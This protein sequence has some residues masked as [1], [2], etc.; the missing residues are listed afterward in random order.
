MADAFDSAL[1]ISIHSS[2]TGSVTDSFVN[3]AG[4]FLLVGVNAR[5]G[6]AVTGITYGAVAMTL[7]G[8]ITEPEGAM[9]ATLYRLSSPPTGTNNIV[10][11]FSG[12]GVEVYVAAVSYS[13]TA[14]SG[15]PDASR[16]QSGTASSATAALTTVVNNAW[17]VMFA[18]SEQGGAAT[19]G[20]GS[21][22]RGS[23]S[24]S[25]LGAFFDSNGAITPAGSYSMGVSWTGSRGFGLVQ[26]SIAPPVTAIFT[27][28]INQNQAVKR[29]STY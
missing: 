18:L 24:S 16:T 29:A 12:S 11:S 9:I 27:K 13:G 15:Q 14:T 4:N 21:T 7:V 3:T 10:T 23:S 1:P 5:A 6:A 2:V 22:I 25:G 28:N 26:M 19:A 8:N 20:T 17:V